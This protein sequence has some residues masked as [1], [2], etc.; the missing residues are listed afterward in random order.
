MQ[1]KTGLGDQPILV[2]IIDRGEL[3]LSEA[4]GKSVAD[5]ALRDWG[6]HCV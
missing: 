6:R 1:P 5:P 4:E 2:P 3:A